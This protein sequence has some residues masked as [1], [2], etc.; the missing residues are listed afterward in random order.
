VLHIL[1]ICTGNYYR[2]RFA[3]LLFNALVAKTDLG[4]RA[5]SRGTRAQYMRSADSPV[6]G[7]V[8]EGLQSRGIEVHQPLHLPTQLTD[9][10]LAQADRIILLNEAE[11]RPYLEAHF[12]AWSD[13]VE[14]WH[15]HDIEVSPAHEALLAIEHHVHGLVEQL[16]E[17][18]GIRKQ[19]A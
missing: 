3:E 18:S 11:H 1:F 17:G 4:W 6:S 9:E 2:S 19:G 12:P 15:V 10:D 8:L 5:I 16:A 13:R 14:Y 7:L